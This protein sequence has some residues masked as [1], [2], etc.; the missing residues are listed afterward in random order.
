MVQSLKKERVVILYQ[1]VPANALA[2]EKDTLVQKDFVKS[3]LI[4]LGYEV[5]ELAVD[6]NLKKLSLRLSRIRPQLVFNLVE[7]LNGKGQLINLTAQ[8]LE[9]LGIPYTGAQAESLFLTS[10]KLLTKKL[11]KLNGIPTP[12]FAPAH[13]TPSAIKKLGFPLL[14]KRI[15]EHASL[16]LDEKAFVREENALPDTST[17]PPDSYFERYIEGREFNVALLERDGRPQPLPVAEIMFIDYPACKPKIVD[18]KAK[19]EPNSFDYQH[20]PPVYEFESRDQ[21]LLA[22]LKQLSLQCWKLFGLKGYARVDFRVDEAGNPFV[23]E[24][25]ANPCLAPEA[26]FMRAALKGG[27]KAQEIIQAILLACGKS[28]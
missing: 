13:A 23:L 17:F 9:S 1:K 5:R 16:G 26:G 12:A 6:L 10:N 19:W 4:S 11:L 27:Y 22:R 18:Y 28:V 7:S 24:I 2:D 25:N 14:L 15:W 21:K 8:L 3:Q 20:T